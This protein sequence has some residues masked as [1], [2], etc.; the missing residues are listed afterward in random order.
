M[1]RCEKI[2]PAA[3]VA[4]LVRENRAKLLRIQAL[5]QLRRQN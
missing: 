5:Q 4:H 1:N 2:V 3:H